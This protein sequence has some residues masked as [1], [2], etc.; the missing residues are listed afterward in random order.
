MVCCEIMNPDSRLLFW[1]N[2]RTLIGTMSMS[3]V[4][5]S[6]LPKVHALKKYIFPHAARVE[7]PKCSR[8]CAQVFKEEIEKV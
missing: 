6:C 2:G 5:S 4:I 3:G 7:T 8:T 1:L